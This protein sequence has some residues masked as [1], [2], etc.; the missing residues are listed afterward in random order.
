MNAL[1]TKDFYPIGKIAV[2]MLIIIF[3]SAIFLGDNLYFWSKSAAETIST[4]NYGAS[5]EI[6]NPENIEKEVKETSKKLWNSSLKARYGNIPVRNVAEGIVHIKMTKKIN[7][8]PVKINVLEINNK[9]NPD[10]EITPVLA[11]EKLS[12]KA[13]IRSLSRK[14]NSV[15]AVNGSFF[16]PKTGVPLGIL[17][18]DKKILTGPIYNRVALGITENGFKMD[19][20]SLDA[21]LTCGENI[22]TVNNLNIPRMLSTDVIVYDGSWGKKSPAPPKNGVLAVVG[23]KQL[24]KLS[25]ESVEIPEN[26]FVISAPKDKIDEFIKQKEVKKFFGRKNINSEINFEIKTIPDWNDVKHIISGGPYLV[27]NGN[28]F[29]DCAEQ[30][31]NSIAGR[32]PRTAAGYTK[33][34]YF[35]IVT[36]DGRE[37]TSVGVNLYDLA[38]IMKSFGCYNAMNLDGG[39][40]TIMQVNGNIVSSPS[41]KGGIA[42]S[43]ALTVNIPQKLAQN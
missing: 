35:I 15:A 37:K 19:R 27:K 41:V 33:D 29:V 25:Y 40:S 21:K 8:R 26:S 3:A 13:S 34:G 14:N 24:I 42:V 2:R 12:G 38:K 17:M 20:V 28:L 31:F 43:N 39:S 30:K 11:G 10:I 16:M 1:L 36:I 5:L 7:G 18:V 32:N 4:E 9:I 6:R 22:L 23:S